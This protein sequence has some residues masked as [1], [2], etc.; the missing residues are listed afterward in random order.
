MDTIRLVVCIVL[1]VPAAIVVNATFDRFLTD[2]PLFQ[3][4]VRPRVSHRAVG[5]LILTLALFVGAQQR[6]VDE[7]W[8]EMLAYCV[9][10]A[11]LL[12]L[13]VIDL[14]EFRLPDA[15]VVPSIAVAITTIVAVSV[16]SDTPERIR[17][18]LIGGAIAFGVLFIA[19]LVSPRGMGFGDVKLAALLGLAVGW[20]ASS[21]NEALILVLWLLLI[22]FGVGTVAGLALYVIRRR[23]EPFPFGPFLAIG[24]VATVLL[25]QVLVA[26]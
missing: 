18:A 6:F 25:S 19:H 14:Y 22:G 20:Q 15:I 17:Y 2:R 1:S 13:S 9:L 5:L 11:V 12:L 26:T 10:F 24:T 21:A 3:S 16:V 4:S 8:P 7:S 23:N